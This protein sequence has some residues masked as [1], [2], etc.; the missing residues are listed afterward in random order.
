M[1]MRAP[2]ARLTFGQPIK[3]DPAQGYHLILISYFSLDAL[4]FYHFYPPSQ[5]ALFYCLT[6]DFQF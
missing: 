1:R 5:F 3:V 6:Q 2:C 4:A